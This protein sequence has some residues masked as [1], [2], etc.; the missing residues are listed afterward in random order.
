MTYEIR[1]GWIVGQLPGPNGSQIRVKHFPQGPFE[2]RRRVNPRLCLHTTETS[3]YVKKLRFPTEFQVGEGIIGQHRPLWARGEAVDIHDH[4]LL[5]IEIVEFSRLNRWLPKPS[6]LNPLVALLALLHRRHFVSTALRRPERWP[7]V[8]DQLPA[9]VDAYYRRHEVWDDPFVYGHVETPGDEHWDPG[10]LD[11][12]ALFSMVRAV[13]DPKEVEGVKLTD[14]QLEGIR[15]AN[16]MRRYLDNPNNEPPEP[17]PHRQGFRF[18]KRI[19]AHIEAEPPVN[20]FEPPRSSTEGMDLSPEESHPERAEENAER[21]R[22]G[23]QPKS[24]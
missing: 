7:T 16:G 14:N 5:Q 1:N 22:L 21:R 8:L 2:R 3:G 11:Y 24:S 9:A 20:E 19:S 15:F 17:G 23:E 12:A 10:S 13:L 6:S 4:D 18:A